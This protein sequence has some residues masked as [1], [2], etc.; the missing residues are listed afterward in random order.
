[1]L[2]MLRFQRKICPG[3]NTKLNGSFKI[4]LIIII[5]L[6]TPLW[7]KR[8]LMHINQN[9]LEEMVKNLDFSGNGSHKT[10]RKQNGI[11]WTIL[12]TYRIMLYQ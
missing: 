8:D 10:T 12:L 2:K 7:L 5:S 3:K 6:F 4:F 9:C 11:I 1:M